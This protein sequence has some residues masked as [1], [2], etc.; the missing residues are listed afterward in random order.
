MNKLDKYGYKVVIKNKA[1]HEG[2][3]VEIVNETVVAREYY[4]NEFNEREVSNS[5][6]EID[7]IPVTRK[8]TPIGQMREISKQ[9]GTG[10]YAIDEEIITLIAKLK[11]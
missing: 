1:F 2:L 11:E 8:K 7:I 4:K 10:N 9:L 5:G 6:F 3:I